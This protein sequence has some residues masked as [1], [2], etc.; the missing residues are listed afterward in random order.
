MDCCEK[1]LQQVCDE[2]AEDINSELCERLRTHLET[3]QDCRNQVASMRST[4]SLFQCLKDKQVP[5][6]IH[7]RLFKLLNVTDDA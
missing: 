1:F 2:L 4:V 3:C 7:E 5:R 6:D